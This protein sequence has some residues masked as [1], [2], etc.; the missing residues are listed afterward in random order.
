MAFDDACSTGFREPR[1]RR[2]A[3]PVPVFLGLVLLVSAA[4]VSLAPIARA[5]TATVDLGTV[6]SYAVLGG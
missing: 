6:G 2:S 5:A 1:L 3:A 4:L